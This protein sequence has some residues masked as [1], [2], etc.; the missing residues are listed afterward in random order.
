[1]KITLHKYRI[2]YELRNDT[3]ARVVVITAQ[4]EEKAVVAL[5]QSLINQGANEDELLI[6]LSKIEYKG[7]I[8]IETKP[9][10]NHEI[11]ESEAFNAESGGSSTP[12]ITRSIAE[13]T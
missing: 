4:T 2:K 12:S 1:M 8:I 7:D 6:K 11:N 10:Q 3:S 13:K 9:K 5:R